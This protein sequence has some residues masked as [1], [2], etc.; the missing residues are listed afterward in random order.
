MIINNNTIYLL[1]L[2]LFVVESAWGRCHPVLTKKL[3][4]F[5]DMSER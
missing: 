2:L 4:K 1:L 3:Q 5:G